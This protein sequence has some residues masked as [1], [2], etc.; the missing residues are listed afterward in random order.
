MTTVFQAMK[1]VSVI[2]E[3]LMA[4]SP[5]DCCLYIHLA[6]P[7]ISFSLMDRKRNKFIALCEYRLPDENTM[8]EFDALFQQDEILAAKGYYKAIVSFVSQ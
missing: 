2:D 5:G 7:F 8:E 1:R 3:S 6:L 4:T